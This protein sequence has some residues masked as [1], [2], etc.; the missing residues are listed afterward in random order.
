MAL[1]LVQT[2]YD[3]I[4][5]VDPAQGRPI[6]APAW[7]YEHLDLNQLGKGQGHGHPALQ[8]PGRAQGDRAGDRQEPAMVQ[9][10]FPG[11]PAAPTGLHERRPVELLAAPR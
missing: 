7:L 1:D 11:A 9:T 5:G 3:A 8:D 4:K 2:D 6:L 10:V